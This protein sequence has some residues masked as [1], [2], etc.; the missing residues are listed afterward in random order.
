M[1]NFNRGDGRN[2][3]FQNDDGGCPL[4]M[5][6]TPSGEIENG[7]CQFRLPHYPPPS[8]D[9]MDCQQDRMLFAIRLSIIEMI[10]IIERL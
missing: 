10:E 1:N 3:F 7:K 5:C 9:M 2:D 4:A 8:E 6:S